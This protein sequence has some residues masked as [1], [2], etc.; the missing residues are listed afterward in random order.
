MSHEVARHVHYSTK[1]KALQRMPHHTII[2]R[3]RVLLERLRHEPAAAPGGGKAVDEQVTVF[4]F[5]PAA[6]SCNNQ[7]HSV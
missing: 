4:A 7:A 5:A 6:G 2:S 1:L 3:V